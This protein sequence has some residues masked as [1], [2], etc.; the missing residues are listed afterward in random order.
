M[1]TFYKLSFDISYFY[2]LAVYFIHFHSGYEVNP[3]NYDVLLFAVLLATVADKWERGRTALLAVALALPAVVLSW[4]NTM[5]G[6]V[7]HILPWAY[8][9]IITVRRGYFIQY[10]SFRTTFKGMFIPFIFPAA[11]FYFNVIKGFEALTESVPYLVVFLASGVLLLQNLRHEEGSGDKKKFE[12]YQ[13]KQTLV[14]FVVCLAVTI[15]RLA[16]LIGNFVYLWIIRPIAAVIIR[17]FWEIVKFFVNLVPERKEIHLDEKFIEH[18]KKL[19]EEFYSPFAEK[20]QEEIMKQDWSEKSDYTTLLIVTGIVAAI[21]GFAILMSHKGKKRSAPLLEDER[22]ELL[23]VEPP[24]TKLRKRSLQPEI[25]VRFHY[26]AF[27]RKVDN[28]TR[29]VLRSDTTAEI[30]KKYDAPSEGKAD[31]VEELTGIYRRTRYSKHL[32]T[33]QEASRVKILMKEI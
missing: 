7:V 27:M 20:V 24:A 8:F 18:Q 31:A 19:E 25:V 32:V 11:F 2:A 23:E 12:K 30:A 13:I 10:G 21:V 26:R 17:I 6:L 5:Y 14:F 16:E 29:N 33:R 15:G 28:K 4:E 1:T 3:L 9:M 22:E